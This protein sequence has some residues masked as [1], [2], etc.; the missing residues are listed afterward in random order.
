MLAVALVSV[1]QAATLSTCG[2]APTSG[3]FPTIQAAVEAAAPGDTVEIGAGSYAEQ[4]AIAKDLTLFAAGAVRWIDPADA[5]DGAVIEVT[6][7]TVTITGISFAT[8]RVRPLLA[9]DADLTLDTCTLQSSAYQTAGGLVHAT[10]GELTIRSTQLGPAIADQGGHVYATDADLTIEGTVARE[11]RAWSSGGSVYVVADLATPDMSIAD[12][13]FESNWSYYEGAAFHGNGTLGAVS[14]DRVEVIGNHAGNEGVVSIDGGDITVVDSKLA[15]N[16]GGALNVAWGDLSLDR[17]WIGD[18]DGGVMASGP[19]VDVL[20]SAFVRNQGSALATNGGATAIT[21]SVFCE[22]RATDG[23]AVNLYASEMGATVS[24]NLFSGNTAEVRGGALLLR[25]IGA[26]RASVVHNDF[27]GNTAA[28]GSAVW[29][30]APADSDWD[31]EFLNN[32]VAHQVAT[33]TNVPL[34]WTFAFA[35]VVQEFPRLDG[36]LFWDNR[37]GDVKEWAVGEVVYDDPMLPYWGTGA[38]C[39]EHD[40]GT[41]YGVTNAVHVSWYGPALDNGV[42]TSDL[43]GSRADIGLT[44]GPLAHPDHWV[45]FDRDGWPWVYDC[46]DSFGGGEDWY[47]GADDPPYEFKDEDCDLTSDQDADKDGHDHRDFGGDDCDDAD[48]GAWPGAAEI[49]HDEIDQDCDGI[50]EL[51][52]D[53]D[54]WEHPIDCD[55]FDRTVN[56]GQFDDEADVDRDCDGRIDIEQP[57]VARGCASAR[58]RPSTMALLAALLA[59]ALVSRRRRWAPRPGPRAR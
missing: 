37:G 5:T 36:N 48:P 4:V 11:G 39:P 25:V 27:L 7:A 34:D 10:R 41:A 52:Y 59:T 51:D 28:H 1:S 3:C 29:W 8:T 33:G 49:P 56:P 44:G 6:D 12:T 58:V 22:N 35:S 30:E 31:V 54:G 57:L 23:A 32:L 21:R 2:T 42:D 55:D 9:V 19:S 45:D 53:R 14:F 16:L 38:A 26:S 24:N 15:G 17:T 18:N 47:P 20:A 46:W 43:D 40:S 13:R 50:D